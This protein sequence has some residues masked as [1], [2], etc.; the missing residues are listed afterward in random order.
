MKSSF[1]PTSAS[2]LNKLCEFLARSFGA[3][4]NAPFLRPAAMAWKYW[5]QRRDWTGPRSYVLEKDGAIVAH[6]GIWPM[7][8]GTEDAIC[9]VQMIDWAAAKESPGSGLSLVQKLAAMFDFIYSIGGSETTRKVLPLFGFVD[10]RRQ[11]K[12]AR[13]LHPLRQI[14]THQERTWKLA[15]R[16]VRNWLWSRTKGSTPYKSW[17]AIEIQPQ[18]IVPETYHFSRTD[19]SFSQRPPAFFE[20]LLRCPTARF[21]LY[22]IFDGREAMG[23]FAISLLRGQARIAGVWLRRPALGTWTAAYYLARQTASRLKGAYEIAAT[24]S[25][26]WSREAAAK[27]GLQIMP[28]PTVYMLN[29]KRSVPLPA[30]FQFQLSDDDAAFLDTGRA[31]YWT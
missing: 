27:A 6:A 26:G 7:T 4:S 2:D 25:E 11:W 16:L 22:G 14:L 12:G 10:Y 29:K 1:R 3:N 17:K 9:G 30:E 24:G 28:G 8:F 20:Y 15:P 21:G 23:H 18:Q 5:D 31:S 19:A 13:P